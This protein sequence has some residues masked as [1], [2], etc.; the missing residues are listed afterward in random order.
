MFSSEGCT[1]RQTKKANFANVDWFRLLTYFAFL[2]SL[3]VVF[4]PKF[5]LQARNFEQRNVLHLYPSGH[6]VAPLLSYGV[7]GAYPCARCR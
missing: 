6:I 2:S 4:T 3:A 7:E 1:T 5:D